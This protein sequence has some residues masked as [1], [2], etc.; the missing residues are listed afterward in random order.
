[1]A[2]QQYLA[3]EVAI[4]HADGL[5]SRREALRR[6]GLVGC[7][8]SPARADGSRS[9]FLSTYVTDHGPAV[10]PAWGHAGSE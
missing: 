6:G 8:L 10:R 4:D 5:Y 9:P 1:M 7:G 2:F 3:E